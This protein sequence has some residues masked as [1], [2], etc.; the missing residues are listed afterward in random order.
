MAYRVDDDPVADILQW[1]GHYDFRE[2]HPSSS[3]FRLEPAELL[4]FSGPSPSA[5]AAAAESRARHNACEEGL[6]E[7]EPQPHFVPIEDDVGEEMQ[8]TEMAQSPKRASIRDGHVATPPWSRQL[9]LLSHRPGRDKQQESDMQPMSDSQKVSPRAQGRAASGSTGSSLAL[10][11]SGNCIKDLDDTGSGSRD[12]LDEEEQEWEE[13][14]RKS[15]TVGRLAV[16]PVGEDPRE[17]IVLRGGGRRHIVVTRVHDGGQAAKVGVRAGDR[18]VSI[19]GKKDFMGHS[20]DEVSEQLK[21]PTILVFL[22]FVGKLKAEVRLTCSD[23]VCGMPARHEVARGSYNHPITLCDEKV[24]NA[25]IASLFLTVASS[26]QGSIANGDEAEEDA[27]R[28]TYSALLPWQHPMFELQHHEARSLVKRA[29]KR[30]EM[31]EP[32]SNVSRSNSV[33]EYPEVPSSESSR[34]GDNKRSLD[35]A[36]LQEPASSFTL[37]FT[38][39]E[40]VPK[41]CTV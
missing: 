31:K 16:Y 12:L 10:C 9:R 5:C 26:A 30:L 22:G 1:L 8:H 27:M 13:R 34:A 2:G 7:N 35:S 21:A 15:G 6:E 3:S 25:G 19:D 37:L 39:G 20:A 23:H 36:S 40:D 17:D 38:A 33:P 24:F 14:Q 41:N 18:L 11:K 32:V 29:M 4:S 28:R